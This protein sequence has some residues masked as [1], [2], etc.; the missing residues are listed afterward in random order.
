[1]LISYCT[2]SLVKFIF[3]S[4]AHLKICIVLLSSKY[5]FYILD[6]SLSGR[7]MICKYLGDGILHLEANGSYLFLQAQCG[8]W[9][10]LETVTICLQ[11][12]LLHRYISY[13]QTI[14]PST[15][16]LGP[17]FSFLV[18]KQHKPNIDELNER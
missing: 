17:Y 18:C 6:F 1:M 2:L 11:T 7:Y 8:P 5:S 14:L 9:Y 15:P 13:F 3:K 12:L 4:F 16:E 10:I